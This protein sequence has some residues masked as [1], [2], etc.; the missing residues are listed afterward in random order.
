MNQSPGTAAVRNSSPDVAAPG[1]RLLVRSPTAPSANGVGPES[2]DMADD[3]KKHYPE[4]RAALVNCLHD[5]ALPETPLGQWLKLWART[6][7]R[8]GLILR[9]AARLGADRETAAVPEIPISQMCH[10]GR[11]HKMHR[12]YRNQKSGDAAGRGHQGAIGT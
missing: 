2:D 6:R 11:H 9:Q 5:A 3:Q 10:Q 8:F 4:N 1:T 12:K 7:G